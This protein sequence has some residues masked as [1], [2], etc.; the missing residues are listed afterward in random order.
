MKR[1]ECARPWWIERAGDAVSLMTSLGAFSVYL[2][3]HV[4]TGRGWDAQSASLLLLPSAPARILLLGLGGG[5]V[6]RQCRHL[7]PRARIVAVEIDGEIVKLARRHFQLGES[8]IDVVH[9][10]AEAF[11]RSS[12]QSFDAILD[13]AWPMTVA[14]P[15]Q[16]LADP[17]WPSRCMRRLTPGGLLGVN[18]YASAASRQ[19][20]RSLLRRLRQTFDDTREVRVPGRL[21]TVL[22]GGQGLR[23]GTK[24]RLAIRCLP[25]AERAHLESL[26]YR[27]R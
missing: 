8:D 23:D 7:F 19:A 10:S 22:V 12:R 5:T 14:G 25:A 15:R 20:H 24:V 6:A 26:S 27:T 16:A 9:D 2:P 13:D 4:F 1:T 18:A 3:A 17:S 21:T 11:V